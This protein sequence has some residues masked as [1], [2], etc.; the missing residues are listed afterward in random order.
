MKSNYVEHVIGKL[1]QNYAAQFEYLQAIEELVTYSELDK[2]LVRSFEDENILE[3][4]LQPERVISFNVSWIDD[5]NKVHVNQGWRVQHSSLIGP[6]KGGLR[7]HPAVNESVFKFLALEQTFKNALT[8]LPIGGAKGGANFDPKGKSNREIMRFCQAFM[9]ELY[10]HI[11]P[12]T[13]I[14]AGD[15]NVGTKE[16]GYLFG[17]YR[18]LENKFSGSLTGKE[19]DFGGS[20]ARIESTGYGIVYF[21][22]QVLEKQG[23]K[24]SGLTITISGAGNVALNAAKKAIEVGAKVLTL[25][26]SQGSLYCQQGFTAD[27]IEKLLSSDSRPDLEKLANK[28]HGKWLEGAKPWQVASDIAIPCATQNELDMNDAKQLKKNAYSYVFE[29]ANMPCTSKAVKFIHDSKIF[30]APAKAVNSGGVVMSTFEMGQNAMF[31]PET[32]EEMDK[33]LKSTMADIYIN[34]VGHQ[35]TDC[36]VGANSFALNKLVRSMIAQGV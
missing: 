21:I 3:R 17:C 26:N 18:R 36:L 32:F 33:K 13:D 34:S 10:R 8:G 1:K 12:N 23:R 19:I 7:F 4:L 6:F 31:F 28:N 24:L 16:I 29:G 25:S 2:S 22:E 5:N 15:I 11:G 30:F 35:S 27:I 14:P 9:R 20:H